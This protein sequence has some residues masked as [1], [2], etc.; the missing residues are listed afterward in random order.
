MKL[1]HCAD[2]H[3]GSKIEAKLPKEKSDERKREVRT[4]FKR[5]VDYAAQND[6]HIILLAG[7]VFD[8][9]RPLKKDKEFFYSVVKNNPEIDFLYL[10]GN[11]DIQE[12]YT[13]NDLANLKT[14]SDEWRTYEYGDLTISGVEIA[15]YN[16][17]S[18]YSTL[19]LDKNKKNIV[20]LHGQA[21]DVSGMD[22]INLT[23][24]RN[25]NIDYLALGHIHSY[26]VAKLDDRA[27]YVYSGCLEGRGF[28]ETGDKGFVEI[29]V[30]DAVEYRFVSCCL[31]KTEEYE[32]NVSGTEDI[33]S[34]YRAVKKS[35]RSEK[36]DIVRVTLTGEID[37]DYDDLAQ[38]VEKYL[39]NDYYF[40]NVKNKTQRKFDVEKLQGDKS[41]HGEF[42]RLV[43]GDTS[44]PEEMK[45]QIISIGLKALGGREIE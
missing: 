42:I 19:K 23:K 17:S 9:D 37:Y 40:V 43:L 38:D 12:S 22:K 32:V 21:G 36:K 28:D 27:V 1:I 3:L 15:P 4:A 41:L 30:N 18:V 20:M 8:S 45:R 26:S 29:S 25:K 35:L 2:I 10:R 16:S 39:E 7:D 14:F 11:H 44:Y 31:R 13:E 6:I 5:L 34:I 33:D 24:L